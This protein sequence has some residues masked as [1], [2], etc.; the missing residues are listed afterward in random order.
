MGKST[1]YSE[2]TYMGKES[3]KEWICGSSH[4]GSVERNLT[5]IDEDAGLIPALNQWVKDPMLL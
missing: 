4:R 1:L 3:E 2:I 5:S